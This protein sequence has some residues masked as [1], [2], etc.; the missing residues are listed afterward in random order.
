[1]VFVLPA[2]GRQMEVFRLVF[3]HRLTDSPIHVQYRVPSRSYSATA[4]SRRFPRLS[5]PLIC[6]LLQVRWKT[7]LGRLSR[8][9]HLLLVCLQ[10][11]KTCLKVHRQRKL[12]AERVTRGGLYDEPFSA[13]IPVENGFMPPDAKKAKLELGPPALHTKLPVNGAPPPLRSSTTETQVPYP[14]NLSPTSCPDSD[15]DKE[16][17]MS[18]SP[19]ASPAVNGA[20]HKGLSLIHI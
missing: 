11:V 19:P 7:F 6:P 18:P 10:R 2:C 12:L 5:S 13:G 20:T 4:N 17:R 9:C 16:E 8:R 14:G 15:I 3:L 1:M